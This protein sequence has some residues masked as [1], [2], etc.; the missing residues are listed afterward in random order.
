MLTV[1]GAYWLADRVLHK[2]PHGHKQRLSDG[3]HAYNMRLRHLGS[4]LQA[5]LAM[6]PLTLIHAAKKDAEWVKW[7]NDIFVTAVFAIIVCASLGVIAVNVLSSRCLTKVP[8]KWRPRLS[9]CQAR[10]PV[11]HAAHA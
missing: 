4:V 5:A 6:G 10:L 7:G 2:N 8:L 9:Y 3:T 1:S 11:E